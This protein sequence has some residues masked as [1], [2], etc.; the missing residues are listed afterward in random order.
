MMADSHV[1]SLCVLFC[2]IS[3]ISS[4]PHL[5]ISSHP[6]PS[7]PI[8]SSHHM[9]M[10]ITSS[11]HHITSHPIPSHLIPSHPSQG[12]ELPDVILVRKSYSH[13]KHRQRKRQFE[14]KSLP[15]EAQ[16]KAMKK[17]DIARE[18]EVSKETVYRAYMTHST[19]MLTTHRSST[20]CLTYVL[21][22]LCIACL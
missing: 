6:T 4:S 7:H 11:H 5:L 10:H 3:A 18:E 20:L 22:V 8:I 17:S 12:K 14:L 9:H 19:H 16:D 15:K 2:F 13:R 1:F 21:Y